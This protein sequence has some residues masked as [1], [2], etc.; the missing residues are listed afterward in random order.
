MTNITDLWTLIYGE[1]GEPVLP[2]DDNPDQN[3]QGL[4]VYRSEVAA[5]SAANYQNTI[6]K[7]RPPRYQFTVVAIPLIE[8]L[9]NAQY[10]RS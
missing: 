4:I 10:Q 2:D 3:D 8:V 1:D 6:A 7:R 9:Q 5:K